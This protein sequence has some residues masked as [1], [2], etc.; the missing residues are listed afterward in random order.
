M[1]GTTYYVDPQ[2]G[3]DTHSGA[4]PSEPLKTSA[5][6]QFLPG[7]T[8]L[9]KR[10]SVIRDMLHTCDGSD[11]KPITYG[12]YGTGGKP[13]FLGSMTA[14]LPTDWAEEKPSVWRFTGAFPSEVCNLVFNG[15]EMC[16]N[17]RWQIDDLKKQGEWHYTLIGKTTG[18]SQCETSG[19]GGILYIFS[20]GNPGSCYSSIECSLWGNRKLAGGSHDIVIE[21]LV[22][23]N[24]GVHGF[25]AVGAENITLRQ[26]EF[27]CIGGAVWNR[28]RRIRFGNAIEFWE[29]GRNL[30][31]EK[32]VFKDIYDSGVTHQ[33]GPPAVIPEQI[34][35]T[36][37][38]FINCGMAAYECREPA[39]KEVYF[40][41][42]TC[43]NAGGG[44]SMQGEAPPRQ[45]EIHPQPMGHHVFIWRI[46]KNSQ[47]GH[48][49]IRNNIFHEAPCGAAIYS[50]IDPADEQ[51]F[52]IDSN[53]Y[54]QTTGRVL[55]HINGKDYAPT[56]FKLY[57]SET[58]K[59]HGSM[60]ADPL[61]LD[62]EKGN[63]RL[64]EKSPCPGWGIIE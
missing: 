22:F 42:N 60:L 5:C 33:G 34:F 25:H 53:C 1:T 63:F 21:N 50:I 10:G 2:D 24:S 35:F 41:Q 61:F 38:L 47:R 46:V 3:N 18:K 56:E 14:S 29:G 8:V 7:D 64:Q 32:C 17:L 51:Q 12:A 39:A 16:G 43:I 57:Q 52:V 15:G 20:D 13:V 11:K 36:G 9:F 54:W 30:L 26:C 48:V 31:V 40:E 45:S 37:N 55:V 28:E 4:A 58:G 27:H 19:A 49:Y 62:P 6:R 23:R 59:D 44:F